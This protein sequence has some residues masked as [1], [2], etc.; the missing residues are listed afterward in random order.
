M[1][2]TSGAH[3][4]QSFTLVTVDFDP[5]RRE[6]FRYSGDSVVRAPEGHPE[7]RVGIESGAGVNLIIFHL[8]GPDKDAAFASHPFQWVQGRGPGARPASE[9]P[10]ITTQNHSETRAV[11]HNLNSLGSAESFKDEL[12]EFHLVVLCGGKMYASPDPTIIN[13]TSPDPPPMT[14][15]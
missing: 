4:P 5:D 13:Q 7:V 10:G 8:T 9:P 3:I 11:M 15:L 2:A 6:K 1:T 14:S 12:F